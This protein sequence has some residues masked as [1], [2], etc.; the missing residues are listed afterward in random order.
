MSFIGSTT[1]STKQWVDLTLDLIERVNIL[2][3]MYLPK[4]LCVMTNSPCKIPKS[5]KLTLFVQHFYD[6]P[7][8]MALESL[9]PLTHLAG[10][11]F[12][13]F[14]L[15]YLESQMVHIHDWLHPVSIN[16]CT[17]TEVA[18][19]FFLETLHNIIYRLCVPTHPGTMMHTSSLTLF[20][21]IVTQVST[22]SW[23]MS[24][25]KPLWF[26]RTLYELYSSV[27]LA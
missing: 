18:N 24:P 27:L 14:Y 5:N 1:A 25:N 19:A 4:L 22:E 26:N 17:T 21:T 10:L 15:Y 20:K 3:T 2:K 8:R 12:P 11:A 16:A 6:N 13:N 9:R 7:P 23:L